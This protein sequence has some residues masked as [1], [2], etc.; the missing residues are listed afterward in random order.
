MCL[1]NEKYS[2]AVGRFPRL[3]PTSTTSGPAGLPYWAVITQVY[4]T[5]TTP[6]PPL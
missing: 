5:G 1:V 3:V 4:V 6:A 2:A